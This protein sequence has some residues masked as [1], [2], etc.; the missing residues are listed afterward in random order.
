MSG[1]RD[2]IGAMLNGN[3]SWS[4]PLASGQ[5]PRTREERIEQH[6][7]LL[8]LVQDL[9]TMRTFANT[10]DAV[11]KTTG[12]VIP[13]LSSLTPITVAELDVDRTHRGRALFA[14]VVTPCIVMNSA[15]TLLDD[16]N[17][18]IV[19][20]AVYNYRKA[21]KKLK[22]GRK[23]AIVEPF[24]KLRSDGTT[25]IRV[26][27]FAEIILDADLAD[28]RFV[29]SSVASGDS[30]NERFHS[31][32]EAT[33][34]TVSEETGQ[35]KVLPSKCPELQRSF[36]DLRILDYKNAG[37]DSFGQRN[38]SEA[39][40][41]YSFALKL[42]D[43]IKVNEKEQ[44]QVGSLELVELWML[45]SNRAMA[46]LKLGKLD[47]ALQDAATSYA[48]APL[49]ATR[50]VVRYAQALTALGRHA[51]AIAAL[52]EASH[53]CGNS[54]ILNDMKTNL[55]SRPLLEVG[56]TR[57]YKT[58]A[59]ALT[60]AGADAE[61]L[62]DVG[63][64]RETL[65][66]TKPVTIRART[67]L[68]EDPIDPNVTGD[69]EWAEIR[70]SFL[71]TMNVELK[72]PQDGAVRIIGFRIVN[73][74]TLWD[75]NWHAAVV[76]NSTVVFRECHVSST[77]G[78][79]VCADSGAYVILEQCTVH[80]GAQGGLLAVDSAMLVLWRTRVCYNAANGLELRQSGSAVLKDCEFFAN[81]RQGILVW[82]GAG[83]LEATNCQIH[84]HKNESGVMVRENQPSKAS[85]R[86]CRIH[87]NGMAGVV[88]EDRGF[89]KLQKC[90][91]TEN[92]EGV[93]IQGAAS[94]DVRSCNVSKNRS[95]GIFIGFDHKSGFVTIVRNR[96][97]GNQG[98]GLLIGTGLNERLKVE[99][100]EEFKNRGLPPMLTA[101]ILQHVQKSGALANK[102]LRKWAK[103]VSKAGPSDGIYG[104]AAMDAIVREILPR[105]ASSVLS[106][107]F[108][109]KPAPA[110]V[111]F[112]RCG[113]C[114]AVCYCSTDCQRRHWKG[115][116]KEEC[117]ATAKHPS[118]LD[119][120]VNV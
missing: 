33:F 28:F 73:E 78:P 80:D 75:A 48:S 84:S 45:F 95:N 19:N 97:E 49:G 34:S 117:M 39:E 93:L 70:S 81:G 120:S 60:A 44:S 74:A 8:R 42:A 98:K 57:K 77:S 3:G 30:S 99:R 11:S 86:E 47:L 5:Q 58:I 16:E 56:P 51:D 62:V 4:Y 24:F 14:T 85:F 82:H 105:A 107:A 53:E 101:N 23:I 40:N 17:G 36:C 72:S 83:S 6:M 64:Y 66:I 114:Q 10:H 15:M 20:L 9:P 27:N 25:G 116:H 52:E 119:P 69:I 37:N 1:L 63:I 46:R 94:A 22:V 110:G 115:G 106:C 26:D 112:A 35:T 29:D 108:C 50:P 118:F 2:M 100:N 102:G 54:E 43:Q 89:V 65:S 18:E 76:E 12:A 59:S 103:R 79:I 92:L 96:L 21:E 67:S 61:I 90:I 113:R 71:S 104:N 68:P 88:V 31:T 7:E 55:L 111:R 38:F 91:L 109:E 41:Q 87:T 32:K 13:G